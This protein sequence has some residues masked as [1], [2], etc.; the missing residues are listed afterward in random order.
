MNYQKQTIK[1][2]IDLHVIET[3]KFKTN[4]L[5]VFI[6]TPLQKETITKQSLIA[7]VLRRGTNKIQSSEEISIKLEEMYRSII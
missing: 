2:G 7:S 6:T 5:S 3:N 4:L 1:E